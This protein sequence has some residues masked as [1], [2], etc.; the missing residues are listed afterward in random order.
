MTPDAL[1]DDRLSLDQQIPTKPA[2][3][4]LQPNPLP[5][6]FGEKLRQLR[7]QH[8]ITQTDLAHALGLA[9][10]GHVTNL[11]TGRRIPSLELALRTA[12]RFHVTVSSMVIDSMSVTLDKGSGQSEGEISSGRSACKKHLTGGK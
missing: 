3:Q 1:V 9:S 5:R 8:A 7:L 12:N 10:H 6:R 11:E 2:P 4:L